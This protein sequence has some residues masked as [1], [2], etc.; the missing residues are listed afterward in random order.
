MLK[1]DYL[2]RIELYQNDFSDSLNT[3]YTHRANAFTF[4]GIAV[5]KAVY[6]RNVKRKPGGN[7]LGNL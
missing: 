1:N 4:R 2:G 5:G 6:V 3:V 7:L